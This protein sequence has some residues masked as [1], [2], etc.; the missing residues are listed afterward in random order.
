MFVMKL[1]NI[2]MVR[3]NFIVFL[4][5]FAALPPIFCSPGWCSR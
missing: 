1:T 3:Q 5:V 2:K 4:N